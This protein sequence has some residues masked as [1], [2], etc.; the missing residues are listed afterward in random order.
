[1]DV[2]FW[3]K[4]RLYMK[5]LT[6]CGHESAHVNRAFEVVG[7]MTLEEARTSR[8]KVRRDSCVFVTKFNP[9][10]PDIQTNFCK[11][12]SVLDSAE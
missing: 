7:A 10:A 11:H 5:Y 6:D 1:M 2:D 12:R 9:R 8:R 4:S 3:E